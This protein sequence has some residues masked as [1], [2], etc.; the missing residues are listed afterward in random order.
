MLL[1]A[2]GD[3]G[4]LVSPPAQEWL[5]HLTGMSATGQTPPFVEAIELAAHLSIADTLLDGADFG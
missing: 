3:P 2:N 1:H 5:S 4:A